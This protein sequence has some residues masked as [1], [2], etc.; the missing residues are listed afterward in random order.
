MFGFGLKTS[1][2]SISRKNYSGSQPHFEYLNR[3]DKY[4]KWKN[5]YMIYAILFIN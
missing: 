5:F 1:L 2:P 3:E 4:L